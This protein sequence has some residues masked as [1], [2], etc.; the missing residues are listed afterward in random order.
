M[1]PLQQATPQVKKNIFLIR[2]VLSL[3]LGS[4]AFFYL[5]LHPDQKPLTLGY[6]GLLLL[7]FLPFGLWDED[8]FQSVRFQDMVF[9]LDLAFLLGALYLF[10]A[11][12][13]NL[14]IMMFLTFFI[15]ALS[16]SMG[17]SFIVAI[18]VVSLYVYFLFTR[19]P[20]FNFMD[21]FFLLSCALIFVVAVHSGY[22]AYRT[23][24]EEKDMVLLARQIDL[25]T[26][27]VQRGDQASL[28]YAG[29]LKNVLDGLPLGAL[30]VSVEGYVIFANAKALK[31]L[32][33][34]PRVLNHADL[35]A[36]DSPLGALGEVMRKSLKERQELKRFYLDLEWKKT[37]KRF[38]LDSSSG[39]SPSGKPWGTLFLIQEAAPAEKSAP[40]EGDAPAQA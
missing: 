14:L 6:A 12:D 25:L 24:Q 35:T 3:I 36:K 15:S 39:I 19:N 27:K 8:R 30:A 29:L 18:L 11:F 13:T 34:S 20:D 40:P 33:L 37:P 28:E 10:D 1:T 5:Q 31:L 9:A 23:V 2:L 32:D 21:P 4:W 7:S 16:Q 26:E 17:R 22:L 38:R